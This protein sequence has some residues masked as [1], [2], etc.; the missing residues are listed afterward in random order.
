MTAPSATEL[1]TEHVWDLIPAAPAG[2]AEE[3]ALDAANIDRPG[4]A[5]GHPPLA[6]R[7]VTCTTG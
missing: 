4:P 2:L 5:Q 3:F 6:D 7:E 1:P